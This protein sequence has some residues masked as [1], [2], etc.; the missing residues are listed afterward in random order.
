MKS[1]GSLASRQSASSVAKTGSASIGTSP[2][3]SAARR[4]R[5]VERWGKAAAARDIDLSL[6]IEEPAG[7]TRC[8]TADLDRVMDVLLDNAVRY[9]PAGSTVDVRCLAGRMEVLDEGSGLAPDE[10]VFDRFYRGSAG[11]QGPGGTGLGLPIA[12]ELAREWGGDVE[13]ENRDGRGAR[14]VVTMPL[15]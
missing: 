15:A 1:I 7:Q 10:P 11:R 5:A 6:T 12:R 3:I 2:G 14:A 13:L 9:S 4:R 8:A